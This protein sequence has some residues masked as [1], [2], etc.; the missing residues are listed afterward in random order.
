MLIT[1]ECTMVELSES[2]IYSSENLTL[3]GL[4]LRVSGLN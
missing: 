2:G 4:L 3:I 1:F